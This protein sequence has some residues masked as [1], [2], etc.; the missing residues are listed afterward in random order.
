MTSE[1]VTPDIQ[2]DPVMYEKQEVVEEELSPVLKIPN[3]SAPLEV[4]W[5]LGEGQT[6]TSPVT[7]A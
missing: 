2:L 1:L 3:S 4:L 5:F 7:N 6:F